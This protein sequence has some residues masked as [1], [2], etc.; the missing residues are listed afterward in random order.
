M[1]SQI[2]P[3][4]YK[5]QTNDGKHNDESLRRIGQAI[6]GGGY[7]NDNDWKKMTTQEKSMIDMYAGTSK[8]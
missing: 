2:N 1:S 7:M 6:A 3:D 4:P 5:Q 8:K